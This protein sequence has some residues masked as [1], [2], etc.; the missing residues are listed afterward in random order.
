MPFTPWSGSSSGG[1]QQAYQ[2][3]PETY[4]ATGNGIV[5]NDVA[6]NGTTTITSPTVAANA[7]AGMAIMINGAN[8]TAVAPLI[9]TISTVTGTGAVL[10]AAAGA[11]ASNCAAIFGN[12][13]TAAINTCVAAAS[14][15]AQ[16]HNYSAEILFGSKNYCLASGPTQVGDGS[17]VPTFNSQIPLPYPNANGT[18]RKLV[19]AF[20]GPNDSSHAQYWIST[21]PNLQG[22]CLVSMVLAPGTGQTAPFG[23]QSVIGG[24]TSAAGFTGGF[25]NVKPVM[26]GITV[27][28]PNLAQ[29]Q[30]YNFRFVGGADLWKSAAQ[31]FASVAGTAPLLDQTGNTTLQN[32]NS[33]GLSMPTSTNNDDC[34]VDTF[35]VEGF[36]FGASFSE[37]F[38]A[39]RLGVLYCNVGF[40]VITGIP[41][42]QAAITHGAAIEYYSCEATNIAI[43]VTANNSSARFPLAIGLMDTEVIN[44]WDIQDSLSNL[45]GI[46]NW[47]DIARTAMN[48]QGAANLNIVN[49][50]LTPGHMASPPAVPASGSSAALVYRD[51][52]VKI[53][54]GVGVAV[55]AVTIDG[56]ATGQTMAASSTLYPVSVPTGKTIALTYAGGTPTWDWW[57]L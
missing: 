5:C 8:G 1:G 56:T 53:T 6:T 3:R 2:F 9:T 48:V 41:A 11:T 16:A 12:D 38:T 25:A 57:L 45:T 31:A 28:I 18:T 55:S 22:A 10:A 47:F 35:V 54:T 19:I 15:Y 49:A 7:I 13:D 42:N 37:H 32:G 43:Q 39:Q 34:N 52:A 14:A 36:T 30:G 40:F 26:T 50:R 44:T 33:I 23:F 20:T 51:A 17:T 27:V 4:G 21:T 24:P 46:V 29:Q